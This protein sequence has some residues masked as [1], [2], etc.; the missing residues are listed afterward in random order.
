MTLQGG[1][2]SAVSESESPAGDV[3]SARKLSERALGSLEAA[4]LTIR[5]LV[6]MHER[7]KQL[8][9]LQLALTT[10]FDVEDYIEHL[11][12][13]V[14]HLMNRLH[15]EVEQL[16]RSAAALLQAAHQDNLPINYPEQFLA[17]VTRTKS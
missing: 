4:R 10:R 16:P 11:P 7:Y 14:Q 9:T 1:G 12:R 13:G 3:P 2:S 15:I 6:N 17:K 8:A 5:V